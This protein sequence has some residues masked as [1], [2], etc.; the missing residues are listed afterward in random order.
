MPPAH[1][2]SLVTSQRAPAITV[3]LR[4]KLAN[5]FEQNRFLLTFAVLASLMGTT[6]GMAQVSASLYAIH[7]GSSKAMLGLIAGSQSVGV[8]L[9]SLP[10][11]L[12]VDRFGPARPFVVGTLLAGLSYAV[13]PLWATPTW[14]LACTAAISFF[15]PLRF[16]SLNT[17]F[18]QQL[19]S[20]G[21]AKAG[22]YR[23]THMLGMFLVGPALGARAISSLGFAWTY[24]LISLGFFATIFV[25]PIVF[26][27]YARAP[28]PKRASGWQVLRSQLTWLAH[29]RELRAVSL[30]EGVTQAVGAFFV[31]FIVVMAVS[32]VHLSSAQASS[33]V[34]AKGTTFIVAL[35][36]LGGLIKRLGQHRAYMVGFAAIASA[37][38]ML[39]FAG[40]APLLWIGS[41]T[42]GLGLGAVQIATLTRYAQIGARN[43]YG[44][45]SGLS[46][47]VGPSGGLF[48]SLFGGLLS[49]WVG[50]S[51]TFSIAAAG[52]ALGLLILATHQASRAR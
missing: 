50:L 34:A 5:F 48:G 8:L 30:I 28:E 16:V 49:K 9:M 12:L 52:F 19:A 35:F 47:L 6:V 14:L 36:I 21:E 29:D 15:M 25:S 13:L 4:S 3:G 44:R 10:I 27:R 41:L 20:L 43:G 26:A 1:G 2:S 40:S 24:R 22:W 37:L 32:V 23:G 39:G 18:L 42:L 31:F 38:A 33:L 46:A 45:V 51:G 7:L 11:G 17:V